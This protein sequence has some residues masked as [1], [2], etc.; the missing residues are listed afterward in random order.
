ME[1]QLNAICVEHSDN[2]IEKALARVPKDMDATYERILNIIN[3]MS[4]TQREL[5]RRAL[6]WTAYAR[7]PLPIDDLAQI[8]SIEG[9]T[10][11]LEDLK[12]SIPTEKDILNACGNL[13]SVDRSPRRSVRFVRFIHFSVQEFLTRHQ[14]EYIEALGMGCEAAHR[15]IAQTCMIYLTLFPKRR[16]FLGLYTCKEW[17]H[18][19][20][21]G[22][23]NS[24]RVDDPI[25][26]LIL[27][28]FDSNPMML[29]KQPLLLE[30]P[31]HLKEVYLKFLLPVLVLMFDLPGMRPLHEKREEKQYSKTIEDPDLGCMILSD[32]NLAMHYAVAE[33]DSVPIARR[34][35]NYGYTVDYSYCAPG[36]ECSKLPDLLQI[37]SLYSVQSIQMARFLL[38]NGISTEPQ[39]LRDTLI[40]PL[41]YFVTRG[42]LGVGVLQLLLNSSVGQNSKRFWL[43]LQAAVRET[44]V[45][46]IQLLLHKGAN[47]NIQGGDT[48]ETAVW[49][50]NVEVIRLLMDTRASIDTQGGRY[51]RAL[52]AAVFD[53]NI[54]LIQLLLDKGADVNM[55]DQECGNALQAAVCADNVEVIQL[56]LDNRADVNIQGG[57]YGST[58]QAAAWV[59]NIDVIRLLLDR[60]ADVNIQGGKNGSALQAAVC[61][62][63]VD[64][65]RLLLDRGADVNMQGGEYG[66]VLQAAVCDDNVEVIRLLLDAG[67]DVNIQGGEY[68]STLQAAAWVGNINVIRLLLDRG[69]EINIQGGENGSALQAAA[70]G[71][72][73]KV[74]RM[75]LKKGADIDMQGG[76][77]GS[78]LQSAVVDNHEDI[79]RLLLDKGA[80][81]NIQGGEYGNS[82][83]AAAW[84]GN[85]EV[86]RLLLYRGADVHARG[87]IYGTALQAAFAPCSRDGSQKRPA[88]ILPVV[89]LLL[90]FGADM[91]TYVP[92]SRYGNALTA[93]N[94][95][96]KQDW[97]SLDALLKLIASRAREGDAGGDEPKEGISGNNM[98][99]L[100]TSHEHESKST[101]ENHVE[102]TKTPDA[103]GLET[104]NRDRLR[105]LV[106]LW[107]PFGFAFMALL[108]YAWIQFW[109]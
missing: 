65:I 106:H 64:I 74:A 3:N 92:G 49:M 69:A 5:A 51:G 41:E 53:D 57:E 46:A 11:S 30:E 73:V 38:T 16:D 75:L 66:N 48:L 27:S 21:A 23:L 85:V 90:D 81:V 33:L 93:A 82:L 34:L 35:H 55:H 99:G 80:S 88:Q 42:N 9:D 72:H 20:L 105:V 107:K 67:A 13:I 12:A 26:T 45:D 97:Y 50:G 7:E 54:E 91:T 87:G 96:W 17:P 86:V 14:S 44:N 39:Q 98:D 40:D 10:K 25:V 43:A 29:L 77:Y 83:Q 70:C 100:E 15:E 22:N 2:G 18:H 63:N 58:L 94:I 52:Q 61:G 95:M 31:L 101:S 24:L 68:G 47:G 37:S 36:E 8:I 1:F 84:R 71:G 56:L 104:S 60:G 4:Q 78:A 19:L 32:D 108:L 103:S 62:G 109:I 6:I 28:F 89:E 79:I 59:G 76:K 102:G